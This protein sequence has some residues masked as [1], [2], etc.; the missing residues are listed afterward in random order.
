MRRSLSLTSAMIT[1]TGK[2]DVNIKIGSCIMAQVTGSYTIHVTA[3]PP[4]TLT[5]AAGPLPDEV[6]GQP[7]TGTIAISG[8]TPPYTLTSATGLPDGVSASLSSDGMSVVLAG[9]PTTVGDSTPI[10]VVSDSGA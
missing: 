6:V 9:S 2:F 1:I 4:L 7:A 8:G 3:I 10:I 5:P